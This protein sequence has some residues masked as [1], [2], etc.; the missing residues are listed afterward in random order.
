MK[1]SIDI[2][3][4]TLIA[5]QLFVSTATFA[6]QCKLVKL[7]S[8]YLDEQTTSKTVYL[9]KKNREM[10]KLN[11]GYDG[12]LLDGNGQVLDTRSMPNGTA[13][14]VYS[15]EGVIYLS[16]K[17]SINKFTHS[18]LVA[19]EKVIVAG[20]MSIRRGQ[21]KFMTDISQRYVTKKEGN[22]KAALYRLKVMG[23][24]TQNTRLFFHFYL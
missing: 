10:Y 8:D 21:L 22:L 23:A 4:T 6:G 24:D 18:S 14:F 15:K 12:L 2:I 16:K 17:R 3:I 20:T 9:S 7:D 1:R 19:G 5:M 11:I 13:T